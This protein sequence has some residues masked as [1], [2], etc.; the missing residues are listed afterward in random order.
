MKTLKF[1]DLLVEHIL[2]GQKTS[3]SRLFDDKDLR[4]GDEVL[5][6]NADTGKEFAK[7][8]IVSAHEKMLKDV[9][10]SDFVG[11]KPFESEE[12][13][14]RIYRSY[15]GEKVSKETIIKII[16]FKLLK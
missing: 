1:K 4:E 2:S 3:S 11:D 12:E 6:I 7:A 10:D 8:C 16:R 15:Y 13:M 14:Y 9:D 5:F